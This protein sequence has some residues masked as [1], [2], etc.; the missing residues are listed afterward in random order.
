MLIARIYEFLHLTQ[1][2]LDIRFY[3]RA[4][5]IKVALDYENIY[6]LSDYIIYPTELFYGYPI[7][8]LS[9]KFYSGNYEALNIQRSVI[10][11][12]PQGIIL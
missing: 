8:L 11:Y 10:G 12:S 9:V 6:Y 1:I 2:C 3:L 5:S 4:T 7:S